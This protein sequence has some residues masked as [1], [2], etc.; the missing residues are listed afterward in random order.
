MIIKADWLIRF[1]DLFAPIKIRA[2]TLFPFIVTGSHTKMDEV[3]L[4][5]E[6]IHLRQ[7]IELL[8][9]PFYIWYLTEGVIRGYRN[10]SFEREAFSNEKDAGY[11]QKRKPYSFFRYIRS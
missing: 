7:Q 6:R 4:N 11:L 5:H 2:I 3:L 1:L 9:I 10:I 8:V